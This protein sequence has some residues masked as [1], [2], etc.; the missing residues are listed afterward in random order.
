MPDA[1]LAKVSYRRMNASNPFQVP[2]CLRRANLEDRRRE[3]LRKSV[4]IGVVAAASVLITLLIGGCVAEHA[5]SPTVAEPAATPSVPVKSARTVAL[6]VAAP[7][8]AAKAA[9][10]PAKGV[11]GEYIVKS[12]DTLARIAGTHH[13]SSRAIKDL[14]NLDR[15]RLTVGAKLKLPAA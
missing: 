4:V 7:S 11:A 15:D 12:G 10:A 2:S 8:A 1:I 6:Q 13:T 14:N 9:P 5:K 3:R